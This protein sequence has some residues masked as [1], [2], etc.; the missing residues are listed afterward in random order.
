[1]NHLNKVFKCTLNCLN[2]AQEQLRTISVMQKTN[3]NSVF[4]SQL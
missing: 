3:K 4:D 2:A 1:M